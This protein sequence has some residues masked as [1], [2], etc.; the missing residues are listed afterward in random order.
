MIIPMETGLNMRYL[1]LQRIILVFFILCATVGLMVVPCMAG[2]RYYSGGPDLTVSLDTSDE[3]VPGTTMELPLVIGNKGIITAEFYNYFTIQPQYIPTTAKFASIRLLAGDAPVRV[4][5]NAQYVGDIQSS[6]VIPATFVVEIPQDAPAGRYTMRANI[7]YQY[8]ARIEQEGTQD[9]EYYFEDAN[10]VIPVP[11]VIRK[12]V[13]LSVDNVYSNDLYAGSE[14]Y[15]TVALRNTGGDTGNH[16][17]VYLVP[18]GASPIVPFSNGIYIGKFP[19]GSTAEPRFK[20]A[21]SST[22]DPSQSYPLSLYAV[23]EDFEGNT[24]TSPSVGT[25]VTFGGKVTFSRVSTPSVIYPG[26]TGIVSVTYKNT[27][28]TTVYNAQARISVIDPFSSD[29]DTAFLG[30]MDPGQSATALFSV[31]TDAGATIK[32]YSADSEIQYTDAANT[33]YISD[34]VPVLIDVQPD[35]VT[36]IIGAVVLILIVACGGYLLHRKRKK[37]EKK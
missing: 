16:S 2:E 14:G 33:A 23:Y 26:K 24:A 3:L 29:D 37:T 8:V 17:S 19:P 30:T 4:K 31:K 27:G 28:N 35:S 1:G 10:T 9:I 12:M 15:I 18:E 7:S 6:A 5:S 32:V 34:N 36:W 21:V 11:V 25:G 22:A 20:V 13:V